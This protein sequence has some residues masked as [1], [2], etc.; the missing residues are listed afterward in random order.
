[1]NSSEPLFL[2]E[3]VID[4]N[5]I[6][7]KY[8]IYGSEVGYILNKCMEKVLLEPNFNTLEKLNEY[9]KE[10]LCNN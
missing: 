6:I 8:N 3:L 1:M 7:N 2:S 9:I 5:Y 4:G 10:I